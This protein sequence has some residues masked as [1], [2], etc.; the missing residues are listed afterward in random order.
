MAK[1]IINTGTS[2][3]DGTGDTLRQAGNKINQNF[4][5]V[6]SLFGNNAAGVSVL[7]D[8]G[9]DFIGASFRTKI[10]HV[11]PTAE[12]SIDFPNATGEVIVTS[13]TQ[14]MENKTLTRPM[15]DS[16]I[17]DRFKMKD[18]D[19]SHSYNFVPSNLAADRNVVLPLLTSHDTL[20]M[21]AHTQTLTN[22]TLAPDNVVHR[23]RVW[24]WIADSAGLP[25]ISFTTTQHSRNRIRVEGK[26]T[27]IN[28]KISLLGTD[29]NIGL[30]IETAGDRAVNI[31]L[32]GHMSESK[33]VG[34]TI[35]LTKSLITL[36]GN[37]GTI[38]LP[39]G[40]ASEPITITIIR[41]TGTGDQVVGITSFGQGSTGVTLQ[42]HDTAT[43]TWDGS[44]W[45]VTGG[46]GYAVS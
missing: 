22:K 12:R 39:D 21:E 7:T 16:A 41:G 43:L 45:Y 29:T 8:S 15:I 6:Y 25:I 17:F 38:T 5:E 46:Y 30:D 31:S 2:A 40:Q 36:T 37:A 26:G 34:D 14:T 18:F 35:S 27:G 10:G 44:N 28:P 32:Y 4:T 20:V 1:Q 9:M 42:Q 11:N 13:A 19:S 24:E 23:P 33:T 3:N